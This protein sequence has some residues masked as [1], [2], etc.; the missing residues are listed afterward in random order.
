M[1]MKPFVLHVLLLIAMPLLVPAEA[2]ALNCLSKKVLDIS[3]ESGGGEQIEEILNELE[4]IEATAEPGKIAD[5]EQKVKGF[6]HAKPNNFIAHYLIARVYLIWGIYYDVMKA[7]KGKTTE[8]LERSLESAEE[9]IR[10][11]D[12]FAETYRLAADLYGWL[13]DLKGA[14][15]YGPFYGLRLDKMLAKA[16]EYDS[17]NPELYL[18]EG[19]KYF[20]KPMVVGGSRKKAVASFEKAITLCPDYYNAHIW[21]GKGYL[22]GGSIEKARQSFE[23]AF[24]LRPDGY[25]AKDELKKISR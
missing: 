7:D 9:S 4:A 13:I 12:N 23:K 2:I 3:L 19:R 17:N 25:E 16:R 20:F 8:S 15:L 18:S 6:V 1:L 11:R 22:D 24:L 21:L 10:L 5:L 14:I